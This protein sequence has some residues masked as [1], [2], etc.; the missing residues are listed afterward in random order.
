MG[1]AVGT[2]FRS[3][4]QVQL[5]QNDTVIQHCSG[6]LRKTR[7]GQKRSSEINSSDAH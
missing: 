6:W 2:R 4:L 7:K 3:T 1:T 5:P